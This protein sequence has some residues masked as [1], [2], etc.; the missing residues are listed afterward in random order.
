MASPSNQSICSPPMVFLPQRLNTLSRLHRFGLVNSFQCYLCIRDSED[1]DH[2]FIQCS[3]RRWILEQ[4]MGNL[5]L[6]VDKIT[7]LGFLDY[8]TGFTDKAKR[9]VPLCYTQV[10]CYHIW[11]ERN[12]RAHN[13]GVFGPAKLL[14]E[15]SKDIRARLH[16]S[17][18]FSKLD[19][20][21]PDLHSCTASL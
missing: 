7:W 6:V 4:L 10:Y 2:L 14:H 15:I 19:C 20:S 5:H 8:L 9:D 21:R 16:G 3:Y 12:A 13:L 1:D 11:R 17:I 18:W